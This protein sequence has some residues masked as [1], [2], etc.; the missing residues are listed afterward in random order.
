[1]NT[2]FFGLSAGIINLIAYVPYLASIL[3]GK[4]KPSRATWIVWF[5][6]TAVNAS[7]YIAAGAR[8]TAW[9]PLVTTVMVCVILVLSIRRGVGGWT[10][11]DRFA[12]AGAGVSLF[13][14][15]VTQNPIVGLALGLLT[16]FFG[17]LPTIQKTWRDADSEDRMT[18][19]LFGLANI[20]NIF[21]ISQWTLGEMLYPV[22]IFIIDAAIVL[23]V[24]VRWRPGRHP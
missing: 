17:A 24:L 11:L 7:S 3:R 22:V 9:S 12:L 20:F 21:A 15:A 4:T 23:P 1:M 14:W 6:I 10:R 19:A 5:A 16:D 18:W 13:G 2:L 8:T